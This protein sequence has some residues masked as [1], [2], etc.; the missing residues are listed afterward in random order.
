MKKALSIRCA[1]FWH[2][3]IESFSLPFHFTCPFS[4]TFPFYLSI[5]SGFELLMISSNDVPVSAIQ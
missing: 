5:F 1:A 4:L 2:W 3:Q